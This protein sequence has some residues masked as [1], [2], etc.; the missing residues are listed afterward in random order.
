MDQSLLAELIQCHQGELYRYLRYLGCRSAAT[1]EDLVQDTFVAALQSDG[2][3]CGDAPGQAA[4]LRGVARNLFLA[5]CRRERNAPVRTDADSLR[6]AE[7]VWAD[8]FL[9][10]GDGYDYVAALRQCLER[11]PPATREL[12]VQRYT[13]GLSRHQL[14]AARRLTADGVKAALRRTRGVLAACIR[15]RLEVEPR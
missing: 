8:E 13:V 6:L 3:T 2:P 12:L 14:A 7:R 10:D 9:R 11:L 4:W 5:H 15:R 1:A